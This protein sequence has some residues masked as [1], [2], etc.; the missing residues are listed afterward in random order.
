MAGP[1][2]N[3]PA[4]QGQSNPGNIGAAMLDVRNALQ[5]LQRALPNIPMGSPLWKTVH[6]TVGKLGKDVGQEQPMSLLNQSALS[7]IKQRSQNPM[8]GQMAKMM[9]GDPNAPPAMPQP[10]PA[11]A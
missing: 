10:P 2:P 5:M 7:L 4:T 9:G 11:S 1:R 3:L 6:D 8:A